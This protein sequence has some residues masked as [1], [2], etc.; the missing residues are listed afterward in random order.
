M[1]DLVYPVHGGLEDWAYG[2]AW[3]NV[4][5]EGVIDDCAPKTYGLAPDGI[6]MKD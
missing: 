5:G 1:N 4:Q 2:A 6:D 3:D